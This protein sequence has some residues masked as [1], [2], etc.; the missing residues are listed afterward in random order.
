MNR[1]YISVG[2]DSKAVDLCCARSYLASIT[3][4]YN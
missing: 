1:Q 2:G 3:I 4:M